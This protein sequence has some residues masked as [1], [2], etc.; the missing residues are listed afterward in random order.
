[1]GIWT[2]IMLLIKYG[3]AVLSI[4]RMIWDLIKSIRDSKEKEVAMQKFSNV[5]RRKNVAAGDMKSQLDKLHEEL[6]QQ[7]KVKK[8]KK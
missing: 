1:M 3:P 4:A 7:L 8:T 5:I 2:I 6:T